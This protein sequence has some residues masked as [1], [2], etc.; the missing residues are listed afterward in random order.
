MTTPTI[1]NVSRNEYTLVRRAYRI[2]R[3]N[4]SSDSAAFAFCTELNSKFRSRLQRWYTGLGE[5]PASQFSTFDAR[6]VTLSSGRKSYR[7]TAQVSRS[8]TRFLAS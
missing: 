7:H 1:R 6:A 3:R 5:R 4:P 8:L 2:A